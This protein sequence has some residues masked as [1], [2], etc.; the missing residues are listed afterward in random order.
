MILIK[1]PSLVILFFGHKVRVI[2]MK[3]TGWGYSDDDDD[4]DDDNDD[5]DDDDD[6][7]EDDEMMTMMMTMTTTMM[8]DWS[9]WER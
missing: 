3:I 2:V 8:T 5:D 4:D 7:D 6:D 1:L 9:D